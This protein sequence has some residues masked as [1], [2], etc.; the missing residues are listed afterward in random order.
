MIISASI[1]DPEP[2]LPDLFEYW[3]QILSPW[4]GDIVDYGK[5]LHVFG[6]PLLHRLAVVGMTTL[7]AIV[8][9]IPQ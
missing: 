2:N 8:D 3:G 7:Y 9:Y 5:G 4:L 1:T 6:P